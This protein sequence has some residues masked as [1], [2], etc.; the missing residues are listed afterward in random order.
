M[1]HWYWI[2]ELTELRLDGLKKA[3][4]LI[5]APAIPPS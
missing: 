5:D 2:D 3:L 4:A 1:E